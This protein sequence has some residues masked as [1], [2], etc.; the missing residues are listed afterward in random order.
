MSRDTHLTKNESELKD[1]IEGDPFPK[2]KEITIKLNLISVTLFKI[3]LNPTNI[4]I[5]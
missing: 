3:D 5:T 1:S 4:G 2:R